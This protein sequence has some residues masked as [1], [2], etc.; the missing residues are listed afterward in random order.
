ML[1]RFCQNEPAPDTE[2]TLM[3]LWL[4]SWWLPGPLVGSFLPKIALELSRCAVHVSKKV[5]FHHVDDSL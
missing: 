5:V 1:G 2:H 4:V 3:V